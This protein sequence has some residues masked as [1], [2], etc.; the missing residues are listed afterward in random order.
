VAHAL[1][2]AVP[3]SYIADAQ[4]IFGLVGQQGQGLLGLIAGFEGGS[5][6]TAV[7]LPVA[8]GLGSET[9]VAGAA[10]VSAA[11]G[12]QS[13]FYSGPGAVVAAQAWQSATGGAQ[14][15]QQLPAGVAA[16]PASAAYAQSASGVIQIF[17]SMEGVEI[18]STWAT[19]EYPTLLQNSNVT[20]AVLNLT[21]GAGQ[22]V[23]TTPTPWPWY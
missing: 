5:V 9:L 21:N 6:L 18:G 22:V 16:G 7:G 12:A 1:L 8:V 10:T 13:G 15:M 3:L 2:R 11:G 23:S 19:S 14:L 4:K 17:Q 20:G